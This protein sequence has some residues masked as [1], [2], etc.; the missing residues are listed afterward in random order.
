[1]CRAF[2]LSKSDSCNRHIGAGRI[3]TDKTMVVLASAKAVR[4][5]HRAPRSVEGGCCER[6]RAD[7]EYDN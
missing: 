6:R 7:E 1:M 5:Y 3:L 2:R 4:Y